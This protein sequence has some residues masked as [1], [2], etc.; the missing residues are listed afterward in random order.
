MTADEIK[1]T[2][3]GWV[4]QAFQPSFYCCV[5]IK[6]TTIDKQNE[7]EWACTEASALF[8]TGMEDKLYIGVCFVIINKLKLDALCIYICTIFITIEMFKKGMFNRASIF[9]KLIV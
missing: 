8:L 3:V 6:K 1:H 2:F 4:S 5:K 7:W 9:K